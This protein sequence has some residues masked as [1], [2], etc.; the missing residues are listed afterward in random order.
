MGN[1]NQYDAQ[2]Y[3]YDTTGRLLMSKTITESTTMIQSNLPSGIYVYKLL[4]AER[5]QK[6]KFIVQ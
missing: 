3:V 4:S 5:S 1:S 6:G 2:F